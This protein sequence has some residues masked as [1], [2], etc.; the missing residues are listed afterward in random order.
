MNQSIDCCLDLMQHSATNL[1]RC[2]A[3]NNNNKE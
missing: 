1:Y 3:N 2:R